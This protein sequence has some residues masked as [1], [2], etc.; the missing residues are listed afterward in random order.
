MPAESNGSLSQCH[1]FSTARVWRRYVAKS[2]GIA[3]R[4]TV[5]ADPRS[6]LTFAVE[7]D[8]DRGV[9]TVSNAGENEFPVIRI[10]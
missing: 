4:R 7:E 8:R 3:Q 1:T 5:A 9:Y 6:C 2:S 10:R